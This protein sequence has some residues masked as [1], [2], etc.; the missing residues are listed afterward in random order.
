MSP[1]S[2]AFSTAASGLS[3]ASSQLQATS[4]KIAAYG[5]GAPGSNDLVQNI[6][7]LTTEKTAFKADA[8]ALKT[9]NQTVGTLLDIFD[10]QPGKR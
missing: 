8:L 7:D 9:M 5:S 10:N 6:V 4:R 1:L 2:S 3:S